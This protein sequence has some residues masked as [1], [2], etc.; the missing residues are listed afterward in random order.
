MYRYSAHNPPL[1]NITWAYQAAPFSALQRPSAPCALEP[2]EIIF[3]GRMRLTLNSCIFKGCFSP[4]WSVLMWT[5]ACKTDHFCDDIWKC[6]KNSSFFKV[7]LIFIHS[8]CLKN[9]SF[10]KVHLFI[11][12]FKRIVSG[13]VN[14]TSP[15]W[16]H[17]FDNNAE[18]NHV[19]LLVQKKFC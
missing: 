1:L 8:F 18:T 4:T 12:T 9:S 6:L 2:W 14:A 7:H 5:Y 15:F 13:E 17:P 3:L 11:H 10:F 19:W 16:G